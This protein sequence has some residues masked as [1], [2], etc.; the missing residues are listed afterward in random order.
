[1]LFLQ[2]VRN[3]VAESTSSMKGH[4]V[5][6]GMM[7]TDYSLAGVEEGCDLVPISQTE[8][9]GAPPRTSGLSALEACM[10]VWRG[11]RN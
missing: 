5:N 10:N 4:P 1:M 7:K 9:A 6:D 8:V 2:G 3:G 11:S